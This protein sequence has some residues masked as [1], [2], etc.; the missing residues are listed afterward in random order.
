MGKPPLKLRAIVTA[1]V[2]VVV[3]A[4]N[5]AAQTL[6]SAEVELASDE[7]R[8]DG[9]R[10]ALTQV[11]Y[12]VTGSDVSGDPALVAGL[13]P[14]PA[15]Y[16]V[17]FRPLESGGLW[18]SFDGSAIERTLRQGGYLVWGDERP[19]TLV[20]LAVDWGDGSREII[21]SDDTPTGTDGEGLVPRQQILRQRVLDEAER[22]GLPLL[23]PL[24]DIE[25]L[26]NVSFADVW[27]GFDD[28]VLRASERYDVDSVLIGRLRGDSVSFARWTH[29]FGGEMRSWGGDVEPVVNLLAD[30]LAAEFAIGGNA[31]LRRVALEVA[32]VTTVDAYASLQK[33]LGEVVVIDELKIT[34]VEGD[35]IAYSVM[36]HGGA[37]RLARALRL[38]GLLE[39]ERI[40]DDFTR[41]FS[42]EPDFEEPVPMPQPATL[43]ERLSFYYTP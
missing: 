9:Y 13:F 1:L 35:R 19:L 36:A 18:V 14:D 28:L 2:L 25:D 8:Q 43:E 21:G 30:S 40:A 3:L 37:A 12:R 15:S 39:E 27:G 23:F 42:T 32:G 5:S 41:P 7:S 24:L 22:R 10:A 33:L 11:L 26:D 38:K 16:V 20:W 4:T 29:H 17:Q 34:G 31:P 6:Y